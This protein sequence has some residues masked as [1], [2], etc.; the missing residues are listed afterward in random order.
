MKFSCGYPTKWVDEIRVAVS[1]NFDDAQDSIFNGSLFAKG[2]HISCVDSPSDAKGIPFDAKGIPFEPLSGH[3]SLDPCGLQ[4]YSSIY[5]G[6]VRV[7]IEKYVSIKLTATFR[8]TCMLQARVC[9][10]GHLIAIC[11]CMPKTQE[12]VPPLNDFL[13][14]LKNFSKGIKILL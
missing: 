5:C 3:G 9:S 13:E 11:I 8:Q 2:K 1:Y 14:P 12:S 4:C 6:I 7:H 10:V